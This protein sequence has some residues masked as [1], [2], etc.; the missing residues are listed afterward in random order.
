M[1]VP[2]GIPRDTD[3]SDGSELF[4]R[5]EVLTAGGVARAGVAPAIAAANRTPVT[6]A[7]D[8]EH[9]EGNEDGDGDTRGSADSILR[10]DS[11]DGELT[12]TVALADDTLTYALAYGGEPLVAPS[13][14]GFEFRDADPLDGDCSISGTRRRSEDEIWKPVWGEASEIR[15]H[16]NELVVGVVEEGGDERSLTL[17]FRAYDDGAA[18]RYVLPKGGQ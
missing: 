3:D 16:Y 6:A 17:V 7:G 10:L 8:G 1:R 9:G 4:G 15:N 13:Q 2:N 14:L 5:R 12:V 18:F 11:P